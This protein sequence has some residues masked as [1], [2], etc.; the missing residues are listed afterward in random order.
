MFLKS[1]GTYWKKLVKSD[2]LDTSVEA[3]KSVDTT[4][5]EERVYETIKKYPQGCIQDDVI[6][7][8]KGLPYSSVTARFAALKRKGYIEL[9]G[10]K[11]AGRSG[12][13]QSVMRAVEQEH[14]QC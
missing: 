9:T 13:N 8:L 14:T 12:K 5:L 10:E 2:G 3:A 6:A 11:K 7:E 1:F 4:R